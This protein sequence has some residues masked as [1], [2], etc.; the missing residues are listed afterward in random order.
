MIDHKGNAIE[1]VERRSYTV[2]G[3]VVPKNMECADFMG[4]L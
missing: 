3:I 4:E 2:N 1:R